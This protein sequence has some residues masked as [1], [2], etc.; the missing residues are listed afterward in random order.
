MDY[1]I[2]L[3]GEDKTDS[4]KHY[5]HIGNKYDITFTNGKSYTYSEDNVQIVESALNVKRNN[6]CF[7]Y[8][9]SLSSA[10]ELKTDSGEII[11]ILENSFKSIKFIEKDSIFCAFLS[12]NFLDKPADDVGYSP[13]YP[14]GFNVSQKKAVERALTSKLSVI[15]GPPGTGKT[16]TIL[17]I[18]ANAVMRGESV[19]VVSNTNSATENVF[20]KLKKYNVDF[21]A[22]PLGNK[23]NKENF[24]KSQRSTLPDMSDWKLTSEKFCDLQQLLQAR[25]GELQT[26]LELKNELSVLKYEVSEYEV[27]QKYFLQFLANIRSFDES[28]VLE[29]PESSKEA[30]DMWLLCDTY[31]GSDSNKGIFLFIKNILEKMGIINRKERKI[32]ELLKRY[33]REQLIV[34]YQRWFYELKIAEIKYRISNITN[35]L[36]D[37]DFESK[38][39]EYSDISL[40]LF[41]SKLAEKYA[42]KK[43][44]IYEL[45]D[46][47]SDSERFISDYPVILSTTYSLR[48]SL[49]GTYDYVI[50]DESSQVDLCTGALILSCAK[51]AVIVGDLKQLPNV[52]DTNTAVKTDAIFEKFD[53]PESYRYK[54]HS[55]L[56]SIIELF[57]NITK[58]LL[59]E[60]YRCHPKIIEFCN[61]KFYDDQLIILTE[62][63]SERTPL[64]VYKTV[65][66]NHARNHI[67]QR[68]V[69]V[70][71]DEIIP[72]HNLNVND[73]SIGVVTPYRNQTS[74]LKNTFK[75]TGVKADTVDKFQGQEKDT[76][77]I[78][79]VDNEIT[80]FADNVNRLNVAVSR[81]IN[82]LIV[83]VNAKATKVDSNIGDLIKYIDYNNFSIFDS[84]VYSVFDYLYKSYAEKR[85][86][87][88][89]KRKRISEYDSEN[90]MYAVITDVLRE[91]Q[92]SRFDVAVHV[93][94]RMIIRDTDKLSATEKQYVENFFTHVDFLIFDKI[95]KLPCLV[96]E[97]DG[98]SFHTAGSKQAHRDEIKNNIFE[99]YGIPLIRFRTDG[100]N[101]RD[102]L[103]VVLRSITDGRG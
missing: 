27:E 19:A 3:K 47:R 96:V 26:K 84:E 39:K 10:I 31:R 25:H 23:T 2:Y 17:N 33:S 73:D 16:Q 48:S 97:V 4:V 11:N 72:K 20:E 42:D 8:I 32:R 63:K 64:V 99:K 76:I 86:K 30:L 44:K 45:K 29:K 100:S 9:K 52:V 80:D 98:V 55:L 77:I 74:V 36:N 60:H 90:L 79:T 101:E 12:G 59:R 62:E 78:S 58:T 93:P 83:V 22:A 103:M 81:A 65:E 95:S 40:S 7:E 82:Q 70:I 43:R 89:E 69:D 94:L 35:E 13:V 67:N 51:S 5:Q 24:I 46:L 14:F 87:F 75:G 37:F 38:M 28:G 71:M 49:P 102:K 21:I 92:F 18:I 53:L 88:L 68:Q 91:K 61:K 15:E 57:P 6:D 50:V 66:G 54:N 41:R 56:S 1:K 34:M 85:L